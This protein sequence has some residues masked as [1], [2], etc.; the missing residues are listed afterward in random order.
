M[1]EKN[2]KEKKKPLRSTSNSIKDLYDTYV[3]NYSAA[4]KMKKEKQEEIK[5]KSMTEE[6][7]VSQEEIKENEETVDT[8]GKEGKEETSEEKI[9]K[10]E[11]EKEE[12]KQNVLRAV[13][14]LENLR[15]RTQKEKEDLITFANERLLFQM[16]SMLDDFEAAIAAGQKSDDYKALLQGVEMIHQKASRLF[17]NSGVKVMEDPTGKEFD[18]DFHE[19]LLTMDS[20]HAEGHVAQLVQKGYMYHDKVLRHAK[21]ATSTGNNAKSDKD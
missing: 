10:L 15:R 3:K 13:A 14:E 5:E 19:A 8:E 18:V 21:V 20:E 17:E 16:L 6:K 1:E 11:K 4:R 7:E 2:K 12:L 9:E